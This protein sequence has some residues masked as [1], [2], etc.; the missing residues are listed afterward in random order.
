MLLLL[1]LRPSIGQLTLKAIGQHLRGRSA[2]GDWGVVCTIHVILIAHD[3][4]L[5]V[6][7]D[8][9]LDVGRCRALPAVGPFEA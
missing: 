2:G 3:E 5:V 9:A 7:Q 4:L 6:A 1:L 8:G